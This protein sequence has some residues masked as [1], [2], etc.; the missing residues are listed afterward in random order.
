MQFLECFQNPQWAISGRLTECNSA[1]QQIKNLR[2][3]GAAANACCVCGAPRRR[4]PTCLLR[5][6]R[7]LLF[8][9]RRKPP[10]IEELRQIGT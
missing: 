4:S 7:L 3:D 8:R 5:Y 9:A 1:I 10:K 2:Y 6:S